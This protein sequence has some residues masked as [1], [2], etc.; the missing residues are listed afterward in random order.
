MNRPFCETY[1][2]NPQEKK[3]KKKKKVKLYLQSLALS[4]VIQLFTETN[5]INVLLSKKRIIR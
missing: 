5:R 4:L 3:R 1:K 2:T